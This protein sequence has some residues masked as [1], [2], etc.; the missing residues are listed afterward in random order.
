MIDDL[1]LQLRRK[2]PIVLQT[3]AAEC[4]LAC[5][6]MISAFH[7][8]RVDLASLRRRYP[9][10]LKGTTLTSLI[11]VASRMELASRALRLELEDLKKLKLPCI[12]HWNLDH[13]VVLRKVGTRSIWIH[14]PA[15]GVRKVS[16]KEASGAFT[17][18]ALELWPATRL[19]RQEERR[20]VRLR[21]LIGRVTGL[22]TAVSQ[23]LL[24]ALVLE[25]F[26]IVSPLILQWVI[27]HVLVSGNRDLLT[28]L[29]VGFGLLVVLQHVIAALRAWMIMHF[30]TVLG[31]QWRAN[32][33]A[34]LLR[35][36]LEYFEKRHLGDIISRFRSID[37][38]QRTLT[39]VFL[40]AVL[41]GMMTVVI[42]V[43]LFFYSPL[44][45]WI[46]I[47]AML[48]YI[49]IRCFAYGPLRLATEEEIVHSAKQ[50]SH[51]L[52]SVRGARSIKLFRR[53][54]ERRGSWL[55]LMVDQVNAG[56]RI[57]KL[58]LL[59]T[60]LNGLLFGLERIVVIWLGALL[61]L[62]GQFSVGMLI[63]FMSYKGQF[64]SRISG[65]IDH[66]FELKMLQVQGERLADIVMTVPEGAGDQ[67]RLIVSED[68]PFQ[69]TIEIQSLRFKYA[70]H[71]PFVLDGVDLSIGAGESIA[72]VG[73]SGCGKTTLLHLMLGILEPTE[74]KIFIGGRDIAHADAATIRQTVA[75]VTQNDTL[76][77]GSI[78]DNI[79]FFDSRTDQEWVEKCAKMAS[80]HSE[81]AEMPMGYNTLIGHMG[82]VLSGGQQQ[83]VL[84]ARALY[85]R[86]KVLILDE[87]TSHLDLKREIMVNSSIRALNV[88]RVI[89]AH[90]PQ[91]AESTD[92]IVTLDSGKISSEVRL[93][94]NIAALQ[95]AQLE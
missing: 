45:T 86:P 28:T 67:S 90:R 57:Q 54:D 53:E 79:S 21:S 31:V 27:D 73:P 38:I 50:E 11:D 85:N 35:L 6:V 33:F 83:R 70:E 14:D 80:I 91:T 46:G 58:K 32:T 29:V 39:T 82:S 78:S 12:I 17:G 56:L 13:F 65:L 4:G 62:D 15:H 74:G 68:E 20:I 89:V 37:V 75:S 94:P 2:L 19:E 8:H 34:H 69:P 47:A 36:P 60:S 55:S 51:F 1:A 93:T 92:R 77:A 5:L 10:S 87:A 42:L 22:V 23:V 41:D 52:E 64:S 63:A 48:I 7:G 44:L 81:I 72:I 9:V 3:E 95:S 49:L 88:T 40:T 25:L 16:L 26:A 71:E 43:V 61:V 30:S 66:F 24:L 76:F 18:V 59:F 84:L